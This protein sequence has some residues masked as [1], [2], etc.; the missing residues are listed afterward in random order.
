MNAKLA[1]CVVVLAFLGCVHSDNPPIDQKAIVVWSKHEKIFEA[2]L[3]GHQRNDEFDKAC[4]FLSK[5]QG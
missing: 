1:M 2:A 3:S 5:L 4:L